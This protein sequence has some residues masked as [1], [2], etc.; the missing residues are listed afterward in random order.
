MAT[1]KITDLSRATT[2]AA[3][4]LVIVETSSGTKAMKYEDLTNPAIEKAEEN[5]ALNL[6]NRNTYRGKNLGS[7]VTAA[8]KAAIQNGSFD[9]LFIGDYWTIGGVKWLIAD[10]DYWYNCGDTA[11]TKHHLVIIP[12]TALY[13][14]QMNATNTTEVGYVNSAMYKTNLANAKSTISSAFGDMVLTHREYLVNAVSNGRPSAGAWMDS[15][16]ELPNECMMYGHPH[17]APACD[18]ST[19]PT[20]YTIDKTQLSLFALRPQLIVNRSHSQWLRDVVSSAYFAIVFVSGS[21]D[22]NG[23]PASSGVRPVFAI[24]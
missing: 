16:V 21:T 1:R 24:G 5:A 17:F 13:N 9:G 10:M 2:P 8:Q 22:Y 15:T 18:G 20:L 23:A 14:A 11:F 7:S 6:D 12:E 4:D 3:N 19:I